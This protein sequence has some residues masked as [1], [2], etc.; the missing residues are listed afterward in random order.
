VSFETYCVRILIDV[1][2]I[3]MSDSIYGQCFQLS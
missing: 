2:E 3:P 1:A